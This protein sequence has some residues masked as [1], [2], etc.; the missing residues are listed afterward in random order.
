MAEPTLYVSSSLGGT[1]SVA[2]VRMFKGRYH[3]ESFIYSI[4]WE[5]FPNYRLDHVTRTDFD[6]TIHE[7]GAEF[8]HSALNTYYD[9]EATTPGWDGAR[10]LY[11][12][13]VYDPSHPTPYPPDRPFKILTSSTPLAGGSTSGGGYYAAGGSC[14]ITAEASEGYEFDYWS[15][16]DGEMVG[17]ES[18]TFTVT[19]SGTW[20][21]HFSTGRF[22]VTTSPDPENGGS[23]TGDGDY[24]YNDYCTLSATPNQGYKFVEWVSSYGESTDNQD[25]RFQVKRSVHWTAK[26]T[27]LPYTIRTVA[28]PSEGGT[29]TG[30]G[31]FEEGDICVIEATAND[32]YVFAGWSS[33][34]GNTSTSTTHSFSVTSD[35]TWTA[36]FA[37][38]SN[39]KRVSIYSTQ[40]YAKGIW[41]IGDGEYEVGEL[42]TIEARFKCS[43]WEFQY[44]S[45]VKYGRIYENPYSFIVTDNVIFALGARH[46]YTGKIMCD[47][48]TGKIMCS[49]SGAIIYEG[50]QVGTY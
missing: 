31:E 42:C 47:N 15:G 29:T 43:P 18:H 4:N 36:T 22:T 20:T 50:I 25:H 38:K 35:E 26:F 46:P 17:S 48:T 39:K 24:A 28:H 13:F 7:E 8:P 14:T 41:W 34:L 19:K 49:P 45:S 30:D 12:H 40:S 23:T 33:D 11:F 16:P 9:Q 21:A 37:K 44:W 6:G 5:A 2:S 10:S 3:D 32:G 27:K 1:A